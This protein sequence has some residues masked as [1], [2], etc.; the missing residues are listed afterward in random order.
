M[1][2]DPPERRAPSVEPT[3][4]LS[5]AADMTAALTDIEI[6]ATLT[7]PIR[8]TRRPVG[9]Q[10]SADILRQRIQAKA[11]TEASGPAKNIWTSSAGSPTYPDPA[12]RTKTGTPH[13]VIDSPSA[14]P[15]N[16][17][18]TTSDHLYEPK[19][20]FCVAMINSLR[21]VI[22]AYL[23]LPTPA[24]G[25]EVIPTQAKSDRPPSGSVSRQQG[26]HLIRAFAS[27]LRLG[28]MPGVQIGDKWMMEAIHPYRASK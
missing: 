11:A 17:R 26:R 5:G 25:S 15:A 20:L 22:I 8:N 10:N 27:T 21:E 18:P 13:K 2:I 1:D 9:G 6:E 14:K 16:S 3:Q 19:A 7:R 28:L 24:W 12:K 4:S 23:F